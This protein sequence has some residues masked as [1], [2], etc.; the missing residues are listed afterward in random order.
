MLNLYAKSIKCPYCGFANRYKHIALEEDRF[1]T[2]K[3]EYCDSDEGGCGEEFALQIA[4][5]SI[6]STSKISFKTENE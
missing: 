3:F 1:V 5:T 2:Q 4:L 6:I